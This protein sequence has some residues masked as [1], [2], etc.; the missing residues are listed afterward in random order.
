MV[1]FIFSLGMSESYWTGTLGKK[2]KGAFEISNPGRFPPPQKA[3]D[4]A[5]TWAISNLYFAQCDAVSGSA[6]KVNVVGSPTGTVNVAF[7]WG[8]GA[9][10]DTLV[11][12]VI[13]ELKA[14]LASILAT[15]ATVEK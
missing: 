14:S 11:E 8:P 12:T 4:G 7:T 6:L 15:S 5:T 13:G 3:E 9:L 2:R 1:R 10:E